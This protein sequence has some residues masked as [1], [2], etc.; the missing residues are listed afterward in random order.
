[1]L[2]AAF[3]VQ[4]SSSI[5]RLSIDPS[6]RFQT[7]DG[8]GVNF[9]GTY[10]R[11][12]QKPMI[13]LLIDDLGATIFRLDP[14]GLSNWEV[15]NDNDDPRVMNWEYYDDRYSTPTFEASW[16]AARYLNHRGLRPF[17]TLSGIVPDWM[18]DD[19]APRPT[20]HVCDQQAATRPPRR[21]HLSPG[22]YDEFAEEVVSMAEYARTH[23]RI[24]FQYFSPMNETDC[25]PAEGP[26]VDPEETPA[27][28]LALARRLRTEGMGD[29][30]LVVPEQAII[31]ND[32]VDPI[33][34]NEELMRQVGAFSFHVYG[35]DNVGAQV[36]RI[37][38]SRYS[39]L[40][41]WLT[42][43]GDLNDRDRSAEN[44]WTNFSLAA[45]RRALIA[46]NEGAS[47]A[48][49]WDAFDNYHEHASRLTF[50]GL[51]Q[52]SD[53]IYS[54]K[55]RYYATRQLYHFVPRGAQLIASTSSDPHFTVAAFRT[56]EHL[57]VVGVKQ[58]G[59]TRVH[60]NLS[61][62]SPYPAMR[63]R[64]FETTRVLNCQDMGAVTP[65]DSGN[66]EF[67]LPDEA[68]F[69]LVSGS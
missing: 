44:D 51:F 40:P 29:V 62:V 27:V 26:R 64:M 5:A 47:T 7:I 31:A 19:R 41:V 61:S 23:A 38:R 55:K 2:A 48:L 68:V 50:Y 32:Y 45:T 66:L 34:A 28:L 12:A 59:P 69:T 1:L 58:G 65:G 25:Y 54:P 67:D 21:D 35:N 4:P 53:H 24:D 10:F 49:Y 8:F 20:H 46:L 36:D 52:N 42:E 30:K 39:W 3:A 57:I 17:L 9:N 16:A 43:Y 6:R 22:K 60:L 13:D 33:L 18:L 63:W 14:Y 56:P 15:V 11:D 37:R